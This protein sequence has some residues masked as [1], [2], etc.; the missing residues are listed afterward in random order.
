M[1]YAITFLVNRPHLHVCLKLTLDLYEAM[2]CPTLVIIGHFRAT[3]SSFSLTPNLLSVAATTTL[4]L[5]T[6]YLSPPSLSLIDLANL[7]WLCCASITLSTASASP[8]LKW[9]GILSELNFAAT[10]SAMLLVEVSRLT[11]KLSITLKGLTRIMHSLVADRFLS[12]W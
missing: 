3:V 6:I 10:S 2:W 11:V 1:N 12:A 7:C 4:I 8:W 9:I 5:T